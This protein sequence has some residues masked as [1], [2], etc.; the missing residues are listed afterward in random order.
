MQKKTATPT[1]TTQVVTPDTGYDGLSS[2][3]V[4]AI[5]YEESDGESGGTTVNI[6]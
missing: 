2:V 5:P 1:Q 4:S 6:G 3:T